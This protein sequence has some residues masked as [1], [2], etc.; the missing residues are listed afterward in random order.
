MDTNGD[1][2]AFV[3]DRI[4]KTRGDEEEEMSDD[5]LEIKSTGVISLCTLK[6]QLQI[7]WKTNVRTARK[8]KLQ[9]KKTAIRFFDQ[10]I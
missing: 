2:D 9:K 3:M 4:P 1:T 10:Q 5:D 6:W 8:V 7:T